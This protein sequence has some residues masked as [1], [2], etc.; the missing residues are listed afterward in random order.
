MK[1]HPVKIDGIDCSLEE[2]AERVC[3][4][5]YDKVA[6]FFDHCAEELRNQANQ[7]MKIGRTQLAILL[8]SGWG[9]ANVLSK[10]FNVIFELCK[11]HMKNEFTN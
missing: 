3:R 9:I 11:P 6:K 10:Q 8:T 5:R 4:M 7:D 1:I 2:L